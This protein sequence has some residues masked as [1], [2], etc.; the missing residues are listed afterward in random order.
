M[1]GIPWWALVLAL[2]GLSVWLYDQISDRKTMRQCDIFG[3]SSLCIMAVAAIVSAFPVHLGNRA[4]DLWNV[5]VHIGVFIV[6]L[7]IYVVV[8]LVIA[9]LLDV[10]RI[11]RG[12]SPKRA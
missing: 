9:E 10:H 6:A 4:S 11:S 5:L 12:G 8:G 3:I 2:F 7:V 1:F